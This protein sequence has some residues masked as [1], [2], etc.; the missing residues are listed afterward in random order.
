MRAEGA[1]RVP[2]GLEQQRSRCAVVESDFLLWNV[3]PS[4][5]TQVLDFELE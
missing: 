2:V 4:I 5:W 3:G 1:R